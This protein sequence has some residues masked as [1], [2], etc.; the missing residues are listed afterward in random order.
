MWKYRKPAVRGTVPG[1]QT[2][3]LVF[4]EYRRT[5]AKTKAASVQITTA[6]DGNNCTLTEAVQ[7]LVAPPRVE[8]R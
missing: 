3:N 7:F 6:A 1:H 5:S 2:L 8:R 4:A